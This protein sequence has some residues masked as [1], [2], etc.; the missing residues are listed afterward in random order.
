MSKKTD[1]ILFFLLCNSTF[2]EDLLTKNFKI[3]I[4]FIKI[5]DCKSGFAMHHIN[6][7]QE[8]ELR[9]GKGGRGWGGDNIGN[10]L[11]YRS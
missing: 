5:I 1:T 8:Y 9:G 2:N 10:P 4:K 11:K 7:R 6:P 3:V